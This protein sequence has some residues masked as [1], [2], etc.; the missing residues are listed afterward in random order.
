[1]N[2]VEM[3]RLRTAIERLGFDGVRTYIN[4]GNLIFETASTDRARLTK[5]V[6]SAIEEEFGFPVPVLLWTAAEFARLVDSLPED[7]VEDETTGRC[8]VLFLWPDV[9]NEG[10]LER[11]PVNPE[12]EQVR[13]LP[14]AVVWRIDRAN[15]TRSRL[16]K[17]VGTPLY[18]QLSIRNSNTVRK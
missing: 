2:R 11:M 17:L 10:V 6:E 13:S 18:R 7:C 4:S 16:T 3:A 5:R 15:A 9:D 14:G 12:V 1:N 8:N